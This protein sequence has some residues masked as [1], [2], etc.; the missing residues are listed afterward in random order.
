MVLVAAMFAWVGSAAAAET[1]RL[2]GYLGLRVGGPP[3]F[4]RADRDS[5]ITLEN[6]GAE[7]L[8]GAALGLAIDRHW[9][10][11]IAGEREKTGLTL[12]S[13]GRKT[14]EYAWY[15]LLLQAR[16]RYP[17][18]EDR[19]SPY[20]LAGLGARLLQVETKD[21]DSPVTF[22]SDAVFCSSFGT[23]VDYF[24]MSNV[25]VGVELKYLLGADSDIGLSGETRHLNTDALIYTFGIRIYYPER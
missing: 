12:E 16:W 20:V 10:F 18:L 17:L 13:T 9:A 2:R 21:S 6:P 1:D 22:A 11:E 25:S 3:Y 8:G 5:E 24:V 7:A 14:A 15:T 23:G 19:L 4:T